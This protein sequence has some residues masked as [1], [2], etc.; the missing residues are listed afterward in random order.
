M[1][2]AT[3]LFER[4]D[5]VPPQPEAS[6]ASAVIVA[7]A[8]PAAA[9]SFTVIQNARGR[10]VGWV[11]VAVAVA[12]TGSRFGA[13]AFGS[14]LAVGVAALLVGLCGNLYSRRLRRP[15]STITVPGLTVLVPGALGFEG[16]LAL[17][18]DSAS[19]NSS[20]LVSTVLMTVGLVVGL[21]VAESIVP[22]RALSGSMKKGTG[23]GGP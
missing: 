15:K 17:V 18:S 21:M 16:V 1:V 23:R 7:L 6:G 19:A 11:F 3:T 8:V 12:V 4:I 5:A 9:V 22:P 20:M 13:W 2:V 14:E 10:D